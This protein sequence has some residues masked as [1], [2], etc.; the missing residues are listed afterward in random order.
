[1]VRGLVQEH[2][3][4][5]RVLVGLSLSILFATAALG[6]GRAVAQVPAPQDV[7][8]SS[9]AGRY[10]ECSLGTLSPLAA[11]YVAGRNGPHSIA[12]IIP[13]QGTIYTYNGSERLPL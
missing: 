10:I 11:D 12:V 2:M 3:V 7:P 1:M 4:M 5:I 8:A 9:S 6:P 13:S